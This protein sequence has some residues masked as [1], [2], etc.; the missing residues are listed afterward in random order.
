VAVERSFYGGSSSGGGDMPL[1]AVRIARKTAGD[2]TAPSTGG[3]WQ[4]LA[5][6]DV[7]L[8]AAVGDYVR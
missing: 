2:M 6:T 3:A 1:A 4:L 7:A 8:P 5:G